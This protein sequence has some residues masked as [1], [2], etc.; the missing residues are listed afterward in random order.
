[1]RKT[2]ISETKLKDVFVKK[3]DW[4]IPAEEALNLGIVD[5]IL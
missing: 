1:M 4:Y 5:E 2:N 3:I